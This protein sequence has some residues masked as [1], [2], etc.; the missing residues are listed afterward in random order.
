MEE[1]IFDQHCL[2]IGPASN[3]SQGLLGPTEGAAQILL[4]PFIIHG[5][6][7]MG[8]DTVVDGNRDLLPVGDGLG[9]TAVPLE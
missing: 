6:F 1:I 2:S 3:Q 7:N 4:L 8:V 9:A 5:Q